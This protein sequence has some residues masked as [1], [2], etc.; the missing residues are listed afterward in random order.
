LSPGPAVMQ[1]PA[2][3]KTD[4]FGDPLPEGAVARIGT[5]KYRV[6]DRASGRLAPDCKLLA[7]PHLWAGHIE[8]WDLPDWSKCR[9]VPVPPVDEGKA[10]HPAQLQSLRFS[11]DGK[12]LAAFDER[13]QRLLFFD[14]ASAKCIRSFRLPD[15]ARLHFEVVMAPTGHK[16]VAVIYGS[17]RYRCFVGDVAKGTFEQVFERAARYLAIA[18]SPDCG[19]AAVV[20]EDLELIDLST[21]KTTWRVTTDYYRSDHQTNTA[22]FTADGKGI[23]VV[24][25]AS[26]RIHD[27]T[28]GRELSN[29]R[30]GSYRSRNMAGVGDVVPAPDGKTFYLCETDV[31]T[32]WDAHTGQRTAA[33]PYPVRGW[34]RQLLFM[35]DGKVVALAQAPYL[36]QYNTLHLWDVTTGKLLTPND[37][38]DWSISDLRFSPEGKLCVGFGSSE[39]WWDPRSGTRLTE[40][41]TNLATP[42]DAFA[43]PRSWKYRPCLLQQ[44]KRVASLLQDTV[45]V[46]EKDTGLETG[47][48]SFQL[49]PGEEARLLA[50]ADEGRYFALSTFKNAPPADGKTNPAEAKEPA[51]VFVWDRESKAAVRAWKSDV[52][53]ETTAALSADGQWLAYMNLQK[54]VVLRRAVSAKGKDEQDVVELTKLSGEVQALAFSHDG[55]QLAC[56]MAEDAGQRK[57]YLYDTPTAKLACVVHSDQYGDVHSL[58][59][60]PDGSLLAGGTRRDSVLVWETGLRGA[61]VKPQVTVPRQAPASPKP[62]PKTPEPAIVGDPLPAGAVRRL[63]TTRYRL[64]E[65]VKLESVRLAPTGSHVCGLDDDGSIVTW[66]LPAWTAGP[67]LR[68]MPSKQAQSLRFKSFVF[69]A[70]GS[71]AALADA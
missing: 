47:H 67:T 39:A 3:P 46:W 52:S 48:F 16:F 54:K 49:N 26:V 15:D 57:V 8:L 32:T 59:Y 68:P 12:N 29:H 28:T 7:V 70:D 25:E 6:A 9:V 18:I 17:D 14:L 56:A 62:F 45:R 61:A 69:A 2:P 1:Q 35:P 24:S 22:E 13:H 64:P 42:L 31:I 30:R 41:V 36:Y 38:P 71:L 21:G 40:P 33:Q 55:Q 53:A 27:A 23:I 44:G 51:R 50:V 37:V 20:G 34:V 19:R 60:S 10:D 11:P 66:K 43:Y 58:I 65:S 4:A 5:I 63:G